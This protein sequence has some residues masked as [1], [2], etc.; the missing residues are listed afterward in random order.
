MAI[1]KDYFFMPELPE[2]ETI[3]LD[4]EKALIAKK[5]ISLRIL[6]PNTV[7]NNKNFFNKNLLGFK[8]LEI[9]RRGK[10]LI[11]KI[12]GG[13]N[14]LL[15][16]LKMT[17]QLIYLEGKNKIAGGHSLKEG[18]FL[19]TVGGDLPNK[20]T[21]VVFNFKDNSKLFFNDLRKFGYLK[22]ISGEELAKILVEN[23]GPEPLEK[24]LDEKYLEQVFKNRLRPI[25]NLLLDQKIIAGLGNIYVDEALFLAGILPN[26][27]A[28]SLKAQELSAL[29]K[30]IK[31]VTSLALKNRGTTFSDYLDSKGRKGNFSKFLKVY[32]RQGET[33]FN[34]RRKI[35]KIKLGGRGTHYCSKCQK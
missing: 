1:A 27:T 2:V 25:K 12:S 8:F 11:F 29:V 7:K 5:I 18:S 19:E 17:G 6:S 28:K 35:M 23:Y 20:Y 3:R 10:L 22:I 13:D 21:R 30:A 33:C 32:G 24:K 15:V 4:L 31:N 26:R 16:H 9:S 14:F 34:C